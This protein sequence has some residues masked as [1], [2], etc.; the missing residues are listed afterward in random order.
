MNDLN[1]HLTKNL[2]ELLQQNIEEELY[3]L[4]M[5][6]AAYEDA[7]QDLTEKGEELEKLLKQCERVLEDIG[8]G[9]EH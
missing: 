4:A 1:R 5:K 7:M 9:I 6:K 8:Y 2:V 3:A